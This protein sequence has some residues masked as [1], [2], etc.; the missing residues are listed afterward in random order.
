[1]FSLRNARLQKVCKTKIGNLLY[2]AEPAGTF[3]LRV[4]MP[5]EDEAE[6]IGLLYLSGLNEGFYPTAYSESGDILCIDIGEAIFAWAAVAHATKNPYQEFTSGMLAIQPDGIFLSAFL[7]PKV[8]KL[9]WWNVSSGQM[10]RFGSNSMVINEWQ[11]GAL[12]VDE[13]FYQVL[14]MPNSFSK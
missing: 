3:A 13:K 12:D 2:C 10:A 7:S 14:S 8:K 1:M 4:D 6:K 9:A 11:V 5:G